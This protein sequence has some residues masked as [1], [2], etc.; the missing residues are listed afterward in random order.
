M[1]GHGSLSLTHSIHMK[2]GHGDVL[3][4]PEALR[5]QR[6]GSLPLAGRQ[7]ILIL[8]LQIPVREP[9]LNKTKDPG[10]EGHKHLQSQH[11]GDRGR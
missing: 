6:Q 4:I 5:R 7:S 2:A 10:C 1:K 9:V 8:E 3:V 11:S